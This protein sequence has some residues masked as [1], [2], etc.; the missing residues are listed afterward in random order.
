MAIVRKPKRETEVEQLIRRGG[1]TPVRGEGETDPK[2][3]PTA[4]VL[5]IPA[6]MLRKIDV[7][8]RGR[9]VRTPRHTWLLEALH[10]K[11]LREQNEGREEP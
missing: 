7:S 10:E 1:G 6:D 8:V 9:P 3:E 2:D 4:I 5:R 11:L